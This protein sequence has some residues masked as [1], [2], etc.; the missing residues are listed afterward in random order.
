[1]TDTVLVQIEVNDKWLDFC[2][3]SETQ[4]TDAVTDFN[5]R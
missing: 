4:L 5:E 2:R 1:M 3:C